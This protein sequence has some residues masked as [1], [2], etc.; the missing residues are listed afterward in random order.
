MPSV[1]S[2]V[3]MIEPI[4]ATLYGL[5]ILGQGLDAMQI[6]GMVLILLAITLLSLAQNRLDVLLRMPL[7]LRK[8][9]SRDAQAKQTGQ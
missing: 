5:L 8:D 3:A 9:N 4:T 2:I 1:A 6:G 7:G